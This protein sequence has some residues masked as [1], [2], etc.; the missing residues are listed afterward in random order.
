[1]TDDRP[2]RIAE[3]EQQEAEL[4]FASFTHDDAWRLGCLLVAEARESAA[5]VAI[6]IRRGGLTLFRCALPG[7]TPDQ[8]AWIAGKS[9]VVLRMES[10]S[11]LIAERFAAYG[12]EQSSGW[13]P[14]PE[15]AV[16]GGS[17]P[18]RVSGVGA[19]AA[20][21]VSGLSSDADHD[22]IVTAIRA[23]LASEA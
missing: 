20:V 11:A 6:D 13:L 19:V 22:L 17:F 16:T 1:M 7:T 3:L 14:M 15:Y 2:G 18:V 8:E 4:E 10:S 12:V 9:A 21:T 23:Y 5:P